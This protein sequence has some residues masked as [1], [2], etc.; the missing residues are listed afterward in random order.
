M[1][2]PNPHSASKTRPQPVYDEVFAKKARN[3]TR[4]AIERKGKGR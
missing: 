4:E 1:P 3:A 2:V